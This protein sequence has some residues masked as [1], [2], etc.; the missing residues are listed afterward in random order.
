MLVRVARQVSRL[1][2]ESRWRR[3][4]DQVLEPGISRLQVVGKVE[5]FS[6]GSPL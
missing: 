5:K 3:N 1:I 4:V 6:P 2:I